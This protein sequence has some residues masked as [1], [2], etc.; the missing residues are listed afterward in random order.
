[1][2]II[3]NVTAEP[4]RLEMFIEYMKKSTKQ[5]TKNELDIL[6][7][8]PNGKQNITSKTST[9]KDVYSIA[10]SLGLIKV[11]DDIVKLSLSNNKVS[12]SE[13]IKTAIFD[14][15]FIN[16]DNMAFAISWLQ[17]Q[18]NIQDLH[19]SA[20]IIDVVNNDLPE[21]YQGLDLTGT[22]ATRWR[23][24][25]YWCVYLGFAT[26]VYI[27]EK[28][29]ICP[30]PTEAIN[31][32]LNSIFTKTK[33]LN[34]K[35]FFRLLSTILPVLEYGNI[36]NKI[37]ESVREGLQL[38]EDTLSKSTSLALLRLKNRNIIK[39]VHKSDADSVLIQDGNENK[40]IS[41]IEYLGK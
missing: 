5:S 26:K 27:A 28:I 30:D 12:V 18:N 35:E 20:K 21:E 2:S 17:T 16:K 39:L 10:E 22:D 32:E 1:M 29:F 4:I 9:F 13:I 41:H 7:S 37:N 34:I 23:H 38:P 36:R 24:F 25:G 6:F 19:W 40:T 8:P 31:N 3:S 33:E 11:E 14:K 15:E